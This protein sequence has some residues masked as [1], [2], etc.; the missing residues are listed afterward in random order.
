MTLLTEAPSVRDLN[1]GFAPTIEAILAGIVA[2]EVR[3][4]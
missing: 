3:A 4:C 1:A 2:G